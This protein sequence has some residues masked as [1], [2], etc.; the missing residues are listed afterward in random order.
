MHNY[1]LG[2]LTIVC[3]SFPVNAQ[4]L[5]ENPQRLDIPQ[6][7][8]EVIYQTT[9]RVL[10]ETFDTEA[11]PFPVTLVLGE[12]TEQYVDNED[13]GIYS[14]HLTRWDEKKFAIS[15]MRL[16]LEHLVDRECR[17]VLVSEILTRTNMIAPVA[18]RPRN[19]K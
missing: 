3:C 1:L 11:R 12:E 13:E 10:G 4:V 15:V 9:L 19:H 18:V 14:I 16:A 17:N 8:A 2:L 6:Q 5:F 7:R